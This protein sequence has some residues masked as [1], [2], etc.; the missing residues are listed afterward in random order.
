MRRA[1]ALGGALA[2]ALGAAACGEPRT[3]REANAGRPPP[4]ERAPRAEVAGERGAARGAPD[5][6]SPVPYHLFDAAVETAD[7]KRLTLRLLVFDP[8]GEANVSKTLRAAF[9]SIAAADSQLVAA[10]AI[11]YTTRAAGEREADLVPIAWGMWVP[12]EGWGAAERSSRRRFHRTYVYFG[13]PPDESIFG[14][15]QR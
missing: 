4:A 15:L 12:P 1:A 7:P 14:G 11:V 3:P 10:R 6:A 9:D 2:L 8:R 5:T 13:T